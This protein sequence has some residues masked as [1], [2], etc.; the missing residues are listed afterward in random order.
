MRVKNSVATH[1]RR[2]KILKAAAISKTTIASF[3]SSV[4]TPPFAPMA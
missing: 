2:K 3:G 1:A 4:S